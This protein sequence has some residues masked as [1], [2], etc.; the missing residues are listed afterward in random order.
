MTTKYFRPDFFV[1]QLAFAI[2]VSKSGVDVEI[3]DSHYN[4]PLHYRS[5]LG[6]DMSVVDLS[7]LVYVHYLYYLY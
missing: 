7:G 5:K 3:L 6:A 2:A 4:C 1:D